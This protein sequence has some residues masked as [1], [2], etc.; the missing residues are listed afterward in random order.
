LDTKTFDQVR[1]N[2]LEVLSTLSD[3][4]DFVQSLIYN[5]EVKLGNYHPCFFI[6]LDEIGKVSSGNPKSPE[7]LASKFGS[8][9]DYSKYGYYDGIITTLDETTLKNAAKSGSLR[10]IKWVALP[11]PG[12]N[13]AV[14]IFATFFQEN[15]DLQIKNQSTN[16]LLFHIIY[17]ASNHW[18]SL[19]IIAKLLK[20]GKINDDLDYANMIDLVLANLPGK[21]QLSGIEDGEK[22][23]CDTI[24]ARERAFD[25]YLLCGTKFEDAISGGYY[26]NTRDSVS[27]SA[28]PLMSCLMIAHW[29]KQYSENH[30]ARL[31]NNLFRVDATR[32][33]PFSY[34]E[35]HAIWEATRYYVFVQYLNLKEAKSEDRIL[36]PI[37]EIYNELGQQGNLKDRKIFIEKKVKISYEFEEISLLLN[38]VLTPEGRL[39]DKEVL[40]K[41]FLV[42]VQSE[43][44]DSLSFHEAEDGDIVVRALSAKFGLSD[45]VKQDFSE[46]SDGYEKIHKVFA[47][48]P[49]L[50]DRIYF[51][52]HSWR[53]PTQH[54][55][56]PKNTIILTKDHLIHLYSSFNQR[57][58][59]GG[60]EKLSINLE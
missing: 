7:L 1:S 6:L 19:E 35:F 14:K 5:N 32:P 13:L 45:Q 39:K 12:A 48:Y 38:A 4:V 9:L 15:E 51:I 31:L 8:L 59:L 16:K 54:R 42:G 47:N 40:S 50:Q 34:E 41:L 49:S 28:I 11:P 24:R 58:Q 43:G 3:P 23:I 37:S 17:L 25:A 36:I 2:V 57:P 46:I 52:V 44:C 27:S 60:P 22:F 18:R 20:Q 21:A 30:L 55:K 29:A 56:I 33:N 53:Q 26:I 10:D